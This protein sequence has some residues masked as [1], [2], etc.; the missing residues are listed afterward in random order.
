[1]IFL[2]LELKGILRS[3]G[4]YYGMVELANLRNVKKMQKSG[5]NSSKKGLKSGKRI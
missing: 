2:V 3:E 5:I 4:L 1:M